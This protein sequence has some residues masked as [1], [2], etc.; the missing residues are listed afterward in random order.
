MVIICNHGELYGPIVGNV[1]VP[2]PFRPWMISHMMDKEEM[3]ALI[4]EG[5]MQRQKWLPKAWKMPLV[6]MICP[7]LLWFSKS[8]YGIPVYR[9]DPRKLMKTFR[10][11]V[12]SMQA[13]D[14]ILIFPED[15]EDRAP[16]ERGYAAE[17][18]GKLYTGFVTIGPA[19]YGKTGKSAVFVP[20]YASKRR[21]TLTIGEGIV[22]QPDAPPNDE[23]M[24][25]VN[26]LRESMQ[27][28]YQQESAKMDN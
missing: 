1:F 22:Y 20:V 23:K 19:Y 25:I 27:Y 4:Y 6:K 10:Q 26:S 15:G 24:R 16:G 3:A 11:T 21:R 2:V 8:L 14:N 7:V 12:E 28:M 18:V 9:G 13:G 5:T 17:G